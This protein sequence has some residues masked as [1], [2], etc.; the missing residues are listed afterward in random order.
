MPFDVNGALKEGYSSAE[1]AEHL[2]KE[3]NFDLPAARQEGYSDDE[4]IADLAGLR[5]DGELTSAAMG[6]AKGFLE[7]APVVAGALAGGKLGAAAG[8][9]GG[10]AAP[11]TVPAG[12]AL[13][14]LGGGAAGWMA[15][16]KLGEFVPGKE[17]MSPDMRKFQAAGET[18]GGA[19]APAGGAFAIP[20]MGATVV[21]RALSR[22]GETARKSPLPFIG[23]ETAAAGSSAVAG[24]AAEATRPG[25]PWTRAGAEFA[26]GFFNPARVFLGLATPTVESL[27]RA[28]SQ[29]SVEGRNARAAEVLQ[30]IVNEA[31]EDP[32]ALARALAAAD[33][34]GVS[35][36][37]AQKTGSPILSAL[38]RK[39]ASESAQFGSEAEKVARESM[40]NIQKSI[41]MLS[42]TGE[43]AALREAAELRGQYFRNLIGLRLNNAEA[44][45]REALAKV[46]PDDVF[47]RSELSRRAADSVEAALKDAREHERALWGAIDKS[48]KVPAH[49]FIRRYQE[50]KADMLPERPLD[51]V[52]EK[53]TQRLSENKGGSTVGELL[54]IRSDFLQAARKADAGGDF[55]DARMYG[56]LAESVL[57]DMSRLNEGK[58]AYDSARQFSRELND[59]FRR[60]FAGDALASNI[61]GGDRLPPELLLSRSFAGGREAGALKTVQLREA[62]DF[63]PGRGMGGDENAA[64]FR[65]A[66]DR[67]MRSLAADAVGPDGNINPAKLEAF[68]KRN[69]ESLQ[70]FP[71]L[72]ADLDQALTAATTLKDLTGKM[73]ETSALLFD[74]KVTAFARISGF[75]DPSRAVGQAV[76][77]SRPVTSLEAMARFANRGGKETREGLQ[78]AIFDHAYNQANKSGQFSFD[79]YDKALTEPMGR[80]LPSVLD[81]MRKNGV[82]T[83]QA[84]DRARVLLDRAKQIE[85]SLN[86]REA[87]DRVLSNPEALYD[88]VLRIAGAKL[89]AATIS[90]HAAPLVAAGAGSKA[91]RTMFDKVPNARIQ[92]VLVE[93]SKNPEFMAALLKKARNPEEKIKLGRQIHGYLINAGLTAA[94]GDE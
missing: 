42:A 88:L 18:F 36:T 10:P 43:P 65:A 84:V 68:M 89:G 4:I 27:K 25:D 74:P 61:R 29:F 7:T 35:T 16:N 79:A 50:L 81:V 33:I 49:H 5:R 77:S 22:I 66:Q 45:T 60:S 85:A 40:S 72:R 9:L 48:E 14:A 91:M 34:P 80:G 32:D 21:G 44:A 70:A 63:M 12:A 87:L 76:N 24:G 51:P 62:V 47:S 23:A 55:N 38:E 67:F 31:G 11:I 71:Q 26:G 93:A 73:R 86:S 30:K 3:K 52:I 39:L 56:Q 59:V 2:A 75:E 20:K 94:E 69:A 82:M 15:G 78:A 17:E 46:Q 19:V 8:A 13:G 6:A 90:G 1:I 28:A 41:D 37:A 64:V 57:D 53:V 92:D 54:K 58:A 83:V